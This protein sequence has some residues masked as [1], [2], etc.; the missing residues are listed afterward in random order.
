MGV[1]LIRRATKKSIPEPQKMDTIINRSLYNSVTTDGTAAAIAFK[2]MDAQTVKTTAPITFNHLSH[3]ELVRTCSVS[4]DQ[5]A[6][7]EFYKRFD[8]YIK[9]Y[10]RKAWKNRS[11]GR[12]INSSCARELLRDL[13]QEVY[14]KLLEDDQQALRNFKG[15]SENS[16]L[17]YLAR[18]SV[19]IVAEHFRKQH[20]EKRKGRM[21]SVDLLLDSCASDQSG[22]RSITYTYLSCNPEAELL[23]NIT[24]RELSEL[25]DEILTGPNQFRDKLI[26][27]LYTIEGLS[28]H[29]VA[30]I[31]SLKLKV[32]SVESILRRTKDR[33]K[34][35]MKARKMI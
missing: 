12:K 30:A 31:E 15:G 5:P 32:S 26:F 14:L 13:S 34:Q 10:V 17:A 2:S 4:P 25:L 8:Y 11:M 23:S 19:N 24:M 6:W 27:K 1:A 3:S 16:F 18:I 21:V 9:I 35:A 28:T 7:D 33:L 20:A 29:Q 22:S